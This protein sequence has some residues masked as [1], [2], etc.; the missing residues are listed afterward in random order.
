[1]KIHVFVRVH[2]SLTFGLGKNENW[3]IKQDFLRFRSQSR[4]NLETSDLTHAS[5]RLEKF[6]DEVRMR[7]GV[8]GRP[9][10]SDVRTPAQTACSLN[11]DR[12][13]FQYS[14]LNKIDSYHVIMFKNVI[15]LSVLPLVL[16]SYSLNNCLFLM[17]L[18]SY[19]I[20]H[21]TKFLYVPK[22]F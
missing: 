18:Q 5:G 1:M 11:S 16:T 10:E 7:T 9:S 2:L 22:Y 19:Q 6:E 17:K 12:H 4:T 13:Q 20:I 14:L 8:L 15:L 21:F 3:L